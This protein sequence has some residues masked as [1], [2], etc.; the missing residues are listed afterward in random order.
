MWQRKQTVFLFLAVVA[1][2]VCLCLPIGYYEPEGMGVNAVL[3]NL[4]LKDADGVAHLSVA[5]L[6]GVLLVTCAIGLYAIFKFKNRIFQARLCMFSILMLVG[7]YLLYG[8]Y[9][10]IA[11]PEGT[12]F[13]FDFS[14]CLPLVSLI[15]YVMAR[16]G[17][18]ADEKLVRAADRIR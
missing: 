6:F 8:F 7:W 12:T 5:A 1:A 14:A 3:Y 10:Y 15:F 16:K 9:G 13:H 17:I 2:F 18:I 11:K 4:W